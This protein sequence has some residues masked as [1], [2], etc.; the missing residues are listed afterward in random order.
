[1]LVVHPLKTCL[2][3]VRPPA[4]L[5]NQPLRQRQ[6]LGFGFGLAK[7]QGLMQDFSRQEDEDEEEYEYENYNDEE[8]EG[9]DEGEGEEV[10]HLTATLQVLQVKTPKGGNIK[11]G[12]NRGG[13]SSLGGNNNRGGS[14]TVALPSP[15]GSPHPSR[16]LQYFTV[17]GAQSCHEGTTFDAP[18]V[19]ELRAVFDPCHPVCRGYDTRDEKGWISCANYEVSTE[20]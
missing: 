10:Y 14:S 13:N 17:K 2:E 8:G 16:F 11:G 3:W 12:N 20:T 5:V 6:G 7:G 9:E 4:I 1:M 19:Y 15:R 18:G